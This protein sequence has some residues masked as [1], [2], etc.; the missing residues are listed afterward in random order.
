MNHQKTTKPT[1]TSAT[2]WIM[3]IT[4]GFVVANIYYNQPL[5]GDIAHTYH[6]NN[7]KAGQVAMLTQVGYALGLLFI[8]PLG[9]MFERK[10]LM[11]VD[12]VFIIASLLITAWAPSINVL[13]VASLFVGITSVLP[14]L[15][16]PMAAHLAKPS[17]RGK[18]IG[19]IMS[20]LLIGIL[21]S[22]TISG[23][24]GGNFGWRGMFYI[25]AGLN[26]IIWALVYFTLP[27]VEPDHKGNYKELMISLVHLIKEEPRLRIASLRGALCFACFSAFWTT[28]VFLLK[29]PQ[30]NLGSEAAGTFGL[31]GAAGAIAAG[32]V[33]KLN[34]RMDA[35]KLSTFT[36]ILIIVSF[37]VF[38]AS[39]SSLIGLAIGV[40]VM[41]VG[42]QATHIS[43]QAIIFAL[44]PLARNRINTV[45]MV[46]YF[47]G[48]SSGTL[49]ASLVWDKFQWN[50]VCTVGIVLSAIVLIVHL[51]SRR[52]MQQPS[53][54][55]HA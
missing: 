42:V 2:L 4:T 32:L 19:F 11:L 46:S 47:I 33:G 29:Q 15:L 28:L 13:L 52:Q 38:M 23:F 21:L 54:V 1:L 37:G 18:K 51:S 35:Y 34:D 17:E 45:Y 31:I 10:R 41:D 44:N 3:T 8:V 5:L 49:L 12:F 20:G 22:R 48:G 53:P 26:L 39:G 9:D 50:G 7:G 36:I 14:Q 30:F 25:A 40:L 24:I 55:A 16:V 43:N 6:V 27:E